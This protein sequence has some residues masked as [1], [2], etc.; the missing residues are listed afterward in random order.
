MRV[1]CTDSQ[2]F[3]LSDGPKQLG[4]L[5]YEGLF[6][7]KAN[8]IVGDDAY[9]GNDDY[10]ITP[11]GIFNTTIAVTKDKMEVASMQMNWKGNIIISFQDGQEYIL[12]A[13]GTF[14]N[15]YVL[16]NK[17]QENL[18]LLEPDFNWTKFTYNYT[19][20]YDQK[21]QDVLLVLLATYAANYYITMMSSSM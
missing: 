15:K 4:H 6:S 3:E 7:S 5:T 9:V 2:T 17:H 19:I 11:K 16:E 12:K 10:M 20:A 13:T 18:M 14:R 21:P 1:Q 8:A